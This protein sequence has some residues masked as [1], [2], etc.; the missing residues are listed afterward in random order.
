MPRKV[1]V[2]V[3]GDGWFQYGDYDGDGRIPAGT[4]LVLTEAEVAEILKNRGNRKS[5][6][7]VE[8]FDS[9]DESV[10]EAHS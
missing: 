5:V 2:R 8:V 6:E 1:R 4:E 3:L 9:D 10:T 7:V